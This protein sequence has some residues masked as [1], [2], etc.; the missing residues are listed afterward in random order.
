MLT[1]SSVIVALVS[2]TPGIAAWWTGRRLTR[3]TDDPAL[4]ELL[5][6][7]QQR[8]TL[9]VATAL[10]VTLVFGGNGAMW[11][12]PLM[13]LALLVGRYPLR[14]FLQFETSNLPRY[15]W[16]SAKSIVAGFGFWIILAWT[17][18]LVL[19][20]DA[21]YRAA[22]AVGLL[23][24]L[25]V[26]ERWYVRIWLRLHEATPLED[27][28][29][30][31]RI[32]AIVER[33]GIAPPALYRIGGPD[34]RY[35]N[36]LALPS[37]HGPAIGLGNRLLE[38]LEPDEAAAI[39]AHELAH[40]EQFSPRR[41]RRLESLNQVLIV[42]A[43]GLPLLLQRL[44]PEGASWVPLLWPLAVVASL[45][46]RA[47]RRQREET[48][49]DLRAAALSGDP[50]AVARGLIKVYVHAFIPRRWPVNFERSASHPSLARRIQALRGGGAQAA[51]AIGEPIVLP[52]ARPGSVVV[53]DDTRAW[54]FD[55]APPDTP[56]SL[57]ALRA[58]ASSMRSVVWSE[59][60]ELR[61]TASGDGRALRASHRRGESWSVP[62]EPAQ[63][64]AVQKALDR[65]D[66]RLHR[67]LGRPPFAGV[68]PVAVLALLAALVAGEV[69]IVLVPA[70]LA[71]VRPG[72]AVIAALG[73][74]AVARAAFALLLGDASWFADRPELGAAA[75]ALVGA[76]AL[77]TAWRR[78]RSQARDDG[79]RLALIV[80]TATTV[81]VL[82]PLVMAAP[83]LPL[84][85]LARLPLLPTL[86]VSLLGL[87]AALVAAGKRAGRW[88][89]LAAGSA[90]LVCGALVLSVSDIRG[91]GE[92][93]A[94]TTARAEVLQRVEF[95][96]PVSGLQL[97]PGGAR[98]V[99]QRPGEPT[100]T[101]APG[102]YAIRYE[103]GDFSGARREIDAMQ[104][105]FMDDDRVLV[106]RAGTQGAELHLERADSDLVLWTTT[107]PTLLAPRLAASP[108]DGTWSVV[109]EEGRSD[110]LY[111]L[112]GAAVPGGVVHRFA[113]LDSVSGMDELVFEGGTRVIIPALLLRGRVSTSL[114]MLQMAT[115]RVAVWE[116]TRD[117]L[118][119][120]SE[121]DG[122][123]QCGSPD[124]RQAICFVRQHSRGRV[125][126]IQA[127]GEARPFSRVP[128]SELA[129]VS[130]GPGP[131]LTV[132]RRDVV[133]AVD[134]ERRRMVDISVPPD[135][136]YLLEAR[137][138]PGLLVALRQGD[139]TSHLVLYRVA[140]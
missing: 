81:L 9:I 98:Y 70:T 121:M 132:A 94:R 89:G 48:E 21:R 93:L 63:V 90:G 124:R 68:R 114:T 102:Q 118:R 55:G 64:A 5:F 99:V 125:W 116:V 137:V 23:V 53:F 97:S 105:A 13:A 129:Q 62:L 17:P 74:M 119:M 73:A 71:L 27:Q 20:T 43:A 66:V 139:G 56:R 115:P 37:L 22:L 50:D 32:R 117:G 108:H 110:S 40:I 123:L 8:L 127:N 7:R 11:G 95:D 52:T 131:T 19:G 42:L 112:A 80:L 3:F 15:L 33:A 44:S 57:D 60:I 6:A 46:M 140:P 14:R 91:T 25:L 35:A 103:V 28:S 134:V 2:V 138:A 69:G 34:A 128:G 45:V 4:P 126:T 39:Y 133:T 76:L 12:I 49:S 10:A 16:R 96:T 18:E 24:G 136:G 83:A 111:V 87:A 77:S 59:L 47:R 92:P 101:G 54:W 78:A 86:A 41:M 120:A 107:L 130:V 84:D 82:I 113:P 30:A 1:A 36:A 106:L 38:L 58:H 67:D 72:T 31:P 109:G 100:M 29:L 88:S 61:V 79:A 26:W 104:I 51:G 65:V 135:A 75:L 122:Y 85:Q